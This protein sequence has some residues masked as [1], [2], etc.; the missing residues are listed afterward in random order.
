[1]G[2]GR[3]R[4]V[5]LSRRA[6]HPVEEHQTLDVRD[7]RDR[8]AGPVPRDGGVVGAERLEADR[9]QDRVYGVDRSTVVFAASNLG[10]LTIGHEA[11]AT[12]PSE[13]TIRYRSEASEN[14]GFPT[15]ADGLHASGGLDRS[16]ASAPHWSLALLFAIVPAC[17]FAAIVRSRRRP[18]EGCCANCGYDLRVQLALS[19]TLSNVE[20]SEQ[21]ESNGRA[22]PGRCPE[23]GTAGDVS[24]R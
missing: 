22:S 8:V 3:G 4:R 20:G 24:V 11:D 16:I 18:R 15:A 12:L 21:S 10:A 6:S 5:R 14:W 17:W 1:M 7:E 23:C 9:Y 19:Q 2:E 13:D